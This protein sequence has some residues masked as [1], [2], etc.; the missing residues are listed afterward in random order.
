MLARAILFLLD[1]LAGFMT[2]ALLLR[3]FMQAFR[4][5]FANPVGAFV[6]AATNWLVLPLRRA[7]P[8]M[9]GLDLASLLPAYALQCL[10]LLVVLLLGGGFFAVDAASLTFLLLWQ[11]LRA[12]LRLAIYLLIGALIVQALLSWISPWSPLGQPL[13][14]L[15][16]PLLRP[17]QR[18]LPPLGG[19]DLSPLAAILLLQLL[20]IFL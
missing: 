7:L 3:F 18:W 13:R 10:V 15:T 6:L 20:L 16:Q 9:F 4:V 2:L 14:Q 12:T 17:I 1:S 5:S 19:V 8:G 11:A